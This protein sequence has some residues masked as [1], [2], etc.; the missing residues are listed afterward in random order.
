[1][2]LADNLYISLVEPQKWDDGTNNYI[3]KKQYCFACAVKKIV[4]GVAIEPEIREKP[5]RYEYRTN[6]Q[7]CECNAYIY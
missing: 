2:N 4:S 3:P 7:C 1:M 6:R 5:D